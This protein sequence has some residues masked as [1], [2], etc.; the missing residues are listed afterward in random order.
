M[1]FKMEKG[2]QLLLR[3]AYSSGTMVLMNHFLTHNRKEL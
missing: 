1:P 2:S 3:K